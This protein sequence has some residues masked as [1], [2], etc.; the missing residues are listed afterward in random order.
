LDAAVF[1][2]LAFAALGGFGRGALGRGI[3]GSRRGARGP[4][5]EASFLSGHEGGDLRLGLGASA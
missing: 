4:R 2:A 5:R 3:D 1:R